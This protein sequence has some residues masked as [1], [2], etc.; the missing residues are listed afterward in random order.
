MYLIN[1]E[2]PNKFEAREV[3]VVRTEIRIGDQ[4]GAVV[5]IAPPIEDAKGGPLSGAILVPRHRD[6]KVEDIRR[7]LVSNPA[8]VFVCR[9]SGSPEGLPS[10]LAKEDVSIVFWGRLLNDRP[11]KRR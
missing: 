11:N 7:G 5:S 8:S 2:E 3:V 9:Y 6:V 10:R 4:D 1:D